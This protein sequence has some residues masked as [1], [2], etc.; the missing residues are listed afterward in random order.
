MLGDQAKALRLVIHAA[1]DVGGLE[2]IC[3]L[4]QAGSPNKGILKA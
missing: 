1:F 4:C 2:A 3:E